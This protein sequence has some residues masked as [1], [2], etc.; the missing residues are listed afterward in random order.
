MNKKRPDLS[1]RVFLGLIDCVLH[2]LS[3]FLGNLDS[4]V[5]YFLCLFLD[6]SSF[7]RLILAGHCEKA[8]ASNDSH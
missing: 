3:G 2:S 6:G 1:G 7:F 4:C 8:H 5:H